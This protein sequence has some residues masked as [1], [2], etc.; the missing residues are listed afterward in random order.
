LAWIALEAEILTGVHPPV[1]LLLSRHAIMPVTWGILRPRILL[2]GEAAQ[3]SPER[4]RV[5]L[6]HECA[7]VD[8][9]DWPIQILAEIVCA[10]YWFHP[11]VRLGCNRL[12]EESEHACDDAVLNAG[13]PAP[14]YAGH[15][16]A[17]ARTLRSSRRAGAVALAM[18]CPSHLE[19]R[20][21]AM[22]NP[23]LNRHGVSRRAATSI[24]LATLCLLVPLAA[25]RAPAQNASGKFSGTVY[26]P[27]GAAI[28]NATVIAS[29]PQAKTRDMT[30]TNAAGFWEFTALPAGEYDVEVLAAG[31][32]RHTTQKI[33]LEPGQN[34]SHNVTLDLGQVSDRINVIAQ[35]TSPST[36]PSTGEPSRVRVGGNVQATKIIYQPRPVYPVTAKA[37]GIQGVV[38]MEGVISKEGNLLSLRVMNSQVDPDLAKAAVDTVKQWRYSP[39]LLNGN[40]VEVVT[41]ID[42][43]FTLIK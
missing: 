4:L 34:R 2:P 5:V 35:G 14:E 1:R 3:W 23:T 18:A 8:R 43:N 27:S 42:V 13:V 25:L 38:T 9:L 21:S 31:F 7:H 10:L 41:R 20:F 16:L 40:P 19:R 6:A 22:L 28:P 24:T 33:G 30:T 29:N 36:A 15:L 39:T 11:L 37:A 26:D 32:A 12:R 17:L